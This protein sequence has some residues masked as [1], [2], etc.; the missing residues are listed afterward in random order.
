MCKRSAISYK[1]LIGASPDVAVKGN[2][3]N[4]PPRRQRD[5]CIRNYRDSL[6]LYIKH[7]RGW[8]QALPR[9]H[10]LSSRKHTEL[11]KKE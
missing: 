8:M 10:H 11:T 2:S 6:T 3:Q 9:V 5:D 4:G 1:G 7:F